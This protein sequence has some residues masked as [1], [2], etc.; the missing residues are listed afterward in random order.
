MTRLYAQRDEMNMPFHGA[1]LAILAEGYV[2]VILRDARADIPW[3][4]FWDFPGGGRENGES[5]V[6]CALRETFE[7]LHLAIAPDQIFWG[8][9]F[10]GRPA[11]SWFF[12]AHASVEALRDGV[13]GDE[14]QRWG[15]M[16]Y[17]GFLNHPRAIPHLQDRFRMVLK[18]IA[19]TKNPPLS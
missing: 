11:R 17:D 1:K 6:A 3:P 8:R 7:E 18:E 4:G 16:R 13:L 5:P 19:Q 2:P 10:G 15:L 12:A 9:P 14:G